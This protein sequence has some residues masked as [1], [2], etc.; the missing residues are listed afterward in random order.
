[1]TEPTSLD[2]PFFLHC[3]DHRHC[4]VARIK[5]ACLFKVKKRPSARA[6]ATRPRD[7]QPLRRFLFRRGRREPTTK[8]SEASF[9]GEAPQAMPVEGATRANDKDERSEL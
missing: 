4:G 8:T 7:L 9:E 2:Q 3:C 6:A 1:M 5:K